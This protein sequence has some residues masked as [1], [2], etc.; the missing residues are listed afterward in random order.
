MRGRENTQGALHTIRFRVVCSTCNSGW[1]SGLEKAAQPYLTP[2]VKGEQ[3]TLGREALDLVSRWIALKVM[4]AEHNDPDSAV[5]PKRLR[6]E[7]RNG[8]AIPY[9]MRIYVA[10]HSLPFERSEGYVRNSQAVVVRPADTSEPDGQQSILNALQRGVPMPSP[11]LGDV[12]NNVQTVTFFL[13]RVFVHVTAARA[14]NFRVEDIAAIPA[15]YDNA[16]IWPPEKQEMTWP[17]EPSFSLVQVNAI[18]DSLRKGMAA[19]RRFW[20]LKPTEGEQGAASAS[21]PHAE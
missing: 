2:L 20:A 21:G 1:M 18:G 14:D 17:C 9:Y 6:M 19:Q 5:T 12:A 10:S 11:P 3:V 16:C 7:F 13:G 15:L 4:V 8:G